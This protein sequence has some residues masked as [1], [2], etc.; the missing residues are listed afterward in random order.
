MGNQGRPY[1]TSE[2]KS[3]HFVYQQA[4]GKQ[5]FLEIPTKITKKNK[6]VNEEDLDIAFLHFLLK[7]Q[8][9]DTSK[10]LEVCVIPLSAL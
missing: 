2:S 7:V 5:Y 8:I 4:P 6:P 9:K 1:G 3:R 10:S